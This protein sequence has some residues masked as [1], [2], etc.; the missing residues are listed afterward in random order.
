MLKI[1]NNYTMEQL[2]SKENF[3]RKN[4]AVKYRK[5]Q[6]RNKDKDGSSYKQ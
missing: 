5:S 2:T 1:H 6:N 3:I 4:I